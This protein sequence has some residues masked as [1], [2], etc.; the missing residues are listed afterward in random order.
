[1]TT[2]ITP[3]TFGEVTERAGGAKGFGSSVMGISTTDI[4]DMAAKSFDITIKRNED[5]LDKTTSRLS[6]LS[7]LD[8]KSQTFHTVIQTLRGL[9]PIK[10][11]TDAFQTRKGVVLSNLGKTGTNYATLSATNNTTERTFSLTIEQLASADS[12]T[13]TAASSVASPTTALGLTA[14]TLTIN[15][16]DV[17]ITGTMSLNDIRDAINTTVG[18]TADVTASVVK[19]GGVYRLEIVPSEDSTATSITITDSNA[20]ATLTGM[21]L[22]RNQY[23][24][25]GATA[26][27][28]VLQN[29]DG[30]TVNVAITSAMTLYD[31]R[32]AINGATIT[33]NLSATVDS[34]GEEGGDLR[35]SIVSKDTGKVVTLADNQ[36]GSLLSSLRLSATSGN[37]TDSLL[38]KFHFNGNAL[39]WNSNDIEGLVE[40][41]TLKLLSPTEASQTLTVAVDPD[42]EI[43]NLRIAEFVTTLEDLLDFHK[44]QRAVDGAGNPL[45]GA[46]LYRD[47]LLSELITT[48]TTRLS[49]PAQGLNA[50]EGDLTS[51]SDIG[52][53]FHRD[54]R[55]FMKVAFDQEKF[56]NLLQ[57][58]PSK[59]Q[60][61]LGFTSTTS[62][63]DFMFLDN[64]KN[65]MASA[66][67]GT[68]ITVTVSKAVDGTYSASYTKGG[69]TTAAV[70][71]TSSGKISD[72]EGS[73]YETMPEIYYSKT[74]LDAM[75]NGSSATT[76]VKMSQ[77]PIDSVGAY[78]D[79]FHRQST[80]YG[81][82]GFFKG[83][84]LQRYTGEIKENNTTL[85]ESNKRLQE[86]ADTARERQLKMLDAVQTQLAAL[87]GMMNQLNAFVAAS[88]SKK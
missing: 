37:T 7:T 35:L 31:I 11:V 30:T 57:T 15:S 24:P 23:V 87:D 66:L 76:I 51:L 48:L 36:S 39:T 38:A 26:G 67:C 27:N 6:A 65:L 77:G 42:L 1:M 12:I 53:T 14:A 62:N 40:G 21:K 86:R 44:A 13:A 82:L 80:D 9:N 29:T 32:N 70:I 68:D 63:A 71:D 5:K 46:D 55:D 20:G 10:G 25:F 75:T 83:G 50:S 49:A 74:L 17:A 43:I 47:S 56:K 3:K 60:K 73:D 59:I 45:E 72:V 78:L 84:I 54:G 28:L 88:E 58:S 52:I 8:S 69:V 22:V 4:A 2:A 33:T 19:D 85:E 18:A 34:Y 41:T 79:E 81:N 61:L 16:Q 64:P